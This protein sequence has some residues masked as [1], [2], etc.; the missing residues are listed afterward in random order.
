MYKV[1]WTAGGVAR[2]RE[3]SDLAEAMNFAKEIDCLVAIK[4]NGMEVIGLFGADGVADGKCPDGV[5]YTW[6]KRRP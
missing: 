5:E 4:G 2:E 1:E 6:K 3:C